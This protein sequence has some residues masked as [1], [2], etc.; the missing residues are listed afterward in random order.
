[1]VE[2]PFAFLEEEMEVIFRYAV[3]A[4]HVALGLAPKVLNA[5]DVVAFGGGLLRVVDPV[6]A[7]LG[8]V[9]HVI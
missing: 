4:T 6:M 3:V 8:R 9:E 7:E 5:V 1:M 2:A